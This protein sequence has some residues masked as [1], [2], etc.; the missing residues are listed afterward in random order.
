M[1]THRQFRFVFFVP[2]CFLLLPSDIRRSL[3]SQNM[4]A[5][6]AYSLHINPSAPRVFVTIDSTMHA[7]RFFG[8]RIEMHRFKAFLSV[9]CT[10]F[11]FL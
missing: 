11:F 9:V 5:L 10:L 2:S 4:S 3:R 1:A 6:N 8:T 7:R